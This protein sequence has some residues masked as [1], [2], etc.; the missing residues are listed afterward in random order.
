MTDLAIR[1]ENL[2]KLY[3]IGARQEAYKTLRESIMAPLR[4]RRS[5]LRYV[6]KE[7]PMK[8]L[9]RLD[10]KSPEME[11]LLKRVQEEVHSV[12]PGAE[13]ILYGSRARGEK[14]VQFRTGIFLY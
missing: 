9:R 1:V 12:L 2:S 7:Q 6:L 10:N 3:K 13:I 4:I 8:T 5:V 14:P 11:T